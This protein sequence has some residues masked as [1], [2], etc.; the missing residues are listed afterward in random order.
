[1][2][3]HII[4]NSCEAGTYPSAPFPGSFPVCMAPHTAPPCVHEKSAPGDATWGRTT[5]DEV[6][7]YSDI[8]LQYSKFTAIDSVF[9]AIEQEDFGYFFSPFI[10]FDLVSEFTPNHY[11]PIKTHTRIRSPN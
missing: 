11:Q 3:V 10:T 4:I 5:G 7:S 1:M 6:F 8:Y 9:S 2:P